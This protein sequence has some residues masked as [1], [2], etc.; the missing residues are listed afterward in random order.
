MPPSH[1]GSPHLSTSTGTLTQSLPQWIPNLRTPSPVLTHSAQN[2][3]SPPFLQ[4]PSLSSNPTSNKNLSLPPYSNLLDLLLKT[5]TPSMSLSISP[6]NSTLNALT[7]RPAAPYLNTPVSAISTSPRIRCHPARIP[8]DRETRRA[9][10]SVCVWSGLPLCSGAFVSSP[11]YLY[12]V[13]LFSSNV[14]KVLQQLV[15]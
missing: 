13:S 9:N 10:G 11:T 7:S 6:H 2:A 5:P 1:P 12:S 15:S 4:P 14:F 3:L 8:S